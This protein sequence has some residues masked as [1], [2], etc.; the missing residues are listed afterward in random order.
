[1]TRC[2]CN[3]DSES[4]NRVTS[5]S[6]RRLGALNTSANDNK[7]KLDFVTTYEI[8]Q[9]KH[10][11]TN[12]NQQPTL[13]CDDFFSGGFEVNDTSA[14]SLF[15]LITRTASNSMEGRWQT[16]G[17]DSRQILAVNHLG[18]VPAQRPIRPGEVVNLAELIRFVEDDVKLVIQ[19]HQRIREDGQSLASG[20]R[21]VRVEEQQ[22]HIG[23]LGVPATH[24]FKVVS[25][26]HVEVSLGHTHSTSSLLLL[27]AAVDG[28][29]SHVRAVNHARSIHNHK[30]CHSDVLAH[31]ELRVMDELRTEHP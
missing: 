1:M 30:V 24:S 21:L 3:S 8:N 13:A 25:S 6:R 19:T 12:S 31:L 18:D 2:I 23:T 26:V 15:F 10:I 28:A 27:L 22:N 16:H 5:L 20:A 29:V 4:P 14:K 17:V 7:H 9:N 11:F